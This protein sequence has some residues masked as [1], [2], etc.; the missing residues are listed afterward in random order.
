MGPILERK[1][2]GCI[3][4]DFCNE[5]FGEPERIHPPAQFGFEEAGWPYQMFAEHP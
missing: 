5:I 2:L 4:A 3:D 1:A